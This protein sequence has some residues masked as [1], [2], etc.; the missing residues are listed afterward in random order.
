MIVGPDSESPGNL[1]RWNGLIPSILPTNA[2]MLMFGYLE[3]MEEYLRNP[4]PFN[5]AQRLL[6]S[7]FFV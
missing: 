6:L 5:P 1:V 4:R 3:S 2:A 7:V